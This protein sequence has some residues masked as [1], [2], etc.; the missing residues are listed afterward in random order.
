[1]KRLLIIG[2]L[3]LAVKITFAQSHLSKRITLDV[4][5]QKLSKVLE[6]ISHKGNFFFS[7]NSSIIKRDSLVTLQAN[8]KTIKQVLDALFKGSYEYRETGNYIIIKRKPVQA[9]IITKPVTAVEKF[10]EINGYVVDG[11]SGINIAE[12]SVYEKSQLIGSLTNSNG[13]FSIRLKSK[14]P[15]AA[16]TVSKEF[17]EDTTVSINPAYAAEIQVTLY[18]IEKNDIVISP[19]D[20]LLPDSVTLIKQTDTTSIQVTEPDSANIDKRFLSRWFVSSAQKIQSL[21]LGDWFAAKPVQV[22]LIPGL[23]TH[24]KLSGQVVNNFSFNILG[25][26]TGGLNGFEVGGFFNINRRDAGYFQAAGFFNHTGGKQAGFQAA[27]L[28]NTV[29]KYTNGFQVAGIGNY[30]KLWMHGFQAAGIINYTGGNVQGFQA[31]GI[32]NFTRQNVN[33]FQ[34]AGIYNH[35]GD[36]MCGMQVSGVSNFVRRDM[37]GIQVAGVV[38]YAYHNK[39]L[40]IGLVNIADTSDGFSIGLINIVRRGYHKWYVGSDETMQ[41]TTSI[42]SGNRKL[43]SIISGGMNLDE[44]RKMYSFGYGLGTEWITTRHFALS[45]DLSSNYLY[46]GTWDYLNLLNRFSLNLHLRISKGFAIYGG[47]SFNMYYSDQPSAMPGYDF[48]VPGNG[49]RRFDVEGNWRGWGGW[50]AGIAIF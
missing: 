20:Y 10:Y 6:L 12:A 2:L 34:A 37:K 17:Y 44:H 43:Y 42:K 25:G 15:Q 30:N 7:Y 28:S 35:A 31:A 40:Q 47:P 29:L 11:I 33:G 49:Y 19:E 32:V 39:G 36:T 16:L 22:S 24:G 13:K 14:Y 27:G 41:L 45:T 23:G 8:N 50:H 26:Y 5:K 9:T 48:D 4:S 21:N 3:L 38:N 18:P 46:L 1:M